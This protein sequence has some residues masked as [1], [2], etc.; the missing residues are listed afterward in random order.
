MMLLRRLDLCVSTLKHGTGT[1]MFCF[2]FSGKEAVQK[3]GRKCD[4][5]LTILYSSEQL[6]HRGIHKKYGNV[7][8]EKPYTTTK[9]GLGEKVSGFH[10]CCC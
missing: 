3:A 9:T 8:L 5:V 4:M 1:I 6:L 2:V 10:A 7:I